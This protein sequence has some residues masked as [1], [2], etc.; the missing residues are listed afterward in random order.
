MEF[1]QVLKANPYHDEKGRFSTQEKAKV[2]SGSGPLF[3]G[4]SDESS[5]KIV[6]EGFRASRGGMYGDGVYLTNDKAKADFFGDKTVKVSVPK[7]FKF[8]RFTE[9]EYEDH[10]WD[11]VSVKDGERRADAF[12]RE[13][14]SKGYKGH[15]VKRN[16]GDEY[17]VV[18]DPKAFQSVT[19]LKAEG[20][21]VV[22]YM[23]KVP[24]GKASKRKKSAFTY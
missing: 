11:K 7:G 12:T 18:H 1:A 16:N 6:E 2:V 8:K 22:L 10:Y 23:R 14:A 5:K 19:V 4:T 15:V 24:K 21:G 20:E 13:M 9:R 17:Y 3:H